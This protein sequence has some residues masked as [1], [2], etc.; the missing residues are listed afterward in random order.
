MLRALE[1]LE[2]GAMRPV[3]RF[4]LGKVDAVM[5]SK[6]TDIEQVRPLPGTSRRAAR[7]RAGIPR[8]R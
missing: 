7:R 1:A 6:V 8:S 3:N 5:Y 2:V 4:H